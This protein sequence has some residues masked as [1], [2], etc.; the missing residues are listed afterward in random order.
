MPSIVLLHCGTNDLQKDLTPQ[1]ITQKILKLEEE[2]SDRSK[3]DV[4]ISGIIIK[5]DDFNAKVKKV[6]E[7]L[8]EIKIRK[9]MK[10]IDN[11]IIDVG[12][13][14]RSNSI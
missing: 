3:R 14:N 11:G 13:L 12:M 7:C 1:K 4:L 10:Y 5:G 9:N 6:H 8:P 2:A